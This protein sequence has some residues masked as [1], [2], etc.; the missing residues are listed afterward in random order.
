MNMA[1]RTAITNESNDF[2]CLYPLAWAQSGGG[3]VQVAK[4]K[5]VVAKL[6]GFSKS[7]SRNDSRTKEPT[8]ENDFG[9]SLLMFKRDDRDRSPSLCR[10]VDGAVSDRAQLLFSALHCSGSI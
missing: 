10:H 1:R 6:P 9:V 8:D 7:V 2:S 3:C 5:K 4:E